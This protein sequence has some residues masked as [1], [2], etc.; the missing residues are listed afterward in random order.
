[1]LSV[2]VGMTETGKKIEAQ[3]E[4]SLVGATRDLKSKKI[5]GTHTIVIPMTP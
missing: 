3:L 1:M 4:E 2:V 5:K